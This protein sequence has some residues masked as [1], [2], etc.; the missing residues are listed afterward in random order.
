MIL[1]SKIPEG[2]LD[3]KWTRYKKTAK[4][5]NPANR[6]KLDVIVIGTGLA[7]SSIAASLG[8]MG[9]QVKSFCF[10]DS[11]RRA[12]SVAAQGG[13]NAAKNYKNDGDSV[14]RM[15]V[16]TLKGGDFRAREANVYRM[17]ECSLNLI[18]QA[19]AQGVPFGREYGGYLNNRSFGGV[20]VSRTFY[21]RGQTG[22]QLLLG[23]YQALMRQ[24]GK[25]TVQLFTRHE[26]LD[27]VVIDGKARG[28]IVR[29]LDTGDIERHAAHT[30]VLA[31][32]GYGK[33][34]YLSTLAMGCNGSAIWR[35]HKK[36]ALMASPSWIQIHPTSL[37]QSGSYQSKLTLMSESLR[38]DGRIWV[39]MKEGET[40]E[41]NAI[42]EEE[43]DYYLER[44]YPA[45]GNLAPRDISSRAAK[46]RIDAGFGI[47]PLKNAV[48]LD[49]AKAIREQGKQKIQEKYG[50]LFDMYEKITGYDAYSVP[51]MISPS[52]HFS[53]GG[54]WVDYELMTSLPGLFALGE[55]NFA[56]HGA[57]RLGANSLLQA[58]VDG[59]FIGPYTI[60]NYLANDIHTGK[61]STDHIAFE[62][63][64]EDVR[65]Q[66]DVFL[67]I[68]GSKTVDYFHK[69]L[70]KILYDYCG[71]ARNEK[72]LRYAIE[73]IRKLKQE[74]FKDVIV[75]GE[76]D[77]LNSE[78]EKAGRVAD[79]FEIGELMCYDALTRNESCG[80][81]F[82]EE[83]QTADGEALR[84]DAEYQFISAW[85]WK[86]ENEEPELVKEPLTFEEIQ[87]TVRSYK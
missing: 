57:N 74:F 71:L 2:P 19:V 21:A 54:L 43:R 46:E 1:N 36:G 81:H 69:T 29:N 83:Y 45:F 73:E 28:V 50:N 59:Y 72:G 67:K 5:V 9:Y 25:G 61:I 70:G 76:A 65:K 38:N 31:T 14:Y 78:L 37:P 11:P 55:A 51:M 49:F 82:R 20:Q 34:Y 27:V 84:N 30:V 18:D 10:Q 79:Y 75:S 56:D 16:D 26:M 58:S 64:E 53:M 87:P 39:P 32:G 68:K 41:P 6:K 35:A 42:P 85:L 23:A 62:R 17:A 66:I 13:V 4:L 33:I 3:E 7:G 47:G 24:V 22:Q 48:Y 40:R 15:F 44:R 8:E 80:A 63:A 86:G 12:H 60:A 77:T 52:A